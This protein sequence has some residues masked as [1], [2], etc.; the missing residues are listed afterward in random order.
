M[1]YAIY[2]TPGEADPLT[3][4]A[5]RWIGRSAFSDATLAPL[6][7]DLA[8]HTASARRYGFHATLKAPFRLADDS[9]E[10]ELI[11]AFDRWT[12]A[13]EPFVGPRLVIGQIDG[14]FALVPEMPNADLDALARDLTV[15]FDAFRASASEAE[16]ARRNPENL[17]T[18]QVRH[19]QEWG[20]PYVMEDFRFHMT[21]TGR[22]TGEEA[23]HLRRRLDKHFGA[24][25]DAPVTFASLALFIEA[26]PGAP[27]TVR[28]FRQLGRNLARK[29]A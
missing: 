22:V 25:L 17:T 20:Y 9:S 3:R 5:E 29:T 28:A 1:R 19:L 18:R 6:D 14:F 7:A 12:A 16:I 10:A 24:L 26:E 15:D 27:F 11:D 23:A 4:A 13:R 21:L 2:F 8:F